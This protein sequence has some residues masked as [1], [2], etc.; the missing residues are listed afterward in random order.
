MLTDAILKEATAEAECFLLSIVPEDGE[1][2]VFSKRFERKMQ[3]LIRRANH[4]IRYQVMRT[5][6]AVALAIVTLFGAVMAVSPE[7]RAAVVGWVKSTFHEFLEYSNEAS[8]TGN[9]VN[10]DT[11]N[12]DSNPPSEPVK[13]DYHLSVVPE[14]YRELNAIDKLDGK[15]Y[16]YVNDVGQIL[17]FTYTYGAENSSLFTKTEEYD[18]YSVRVNK[19][20]ADVYISINKSETSVIIWQDSEKTVLFEIFAMADQEELIKIAGTVEAIKT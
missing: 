12:E 8:N 16:L 13:Y 20:S 17:Q 15:R 11:N 9:N 4:P 2:H 6:A 19:W 10:D 3:K 18:Q 14:G 5:A 7:A 1:P